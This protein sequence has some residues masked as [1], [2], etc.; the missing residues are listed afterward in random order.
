LARSHRPAGRSYLTP[1]ARLGPSAMGGQGLIA[2]APIPRD[3]LVAIWGNWIMTTAEMWA[4]PAALQ[5]FPVQV[6]YDMFV[7]P[8]SARDVEAVDY[9]NHSCAPNCG[10]RGSVV[11]VARQ[12][13]AAGEELTF[14]YGTT[15]TD[16]W[17]LDCGCG[18]ATCRGRMTG[19]D[20]RDPAFQE[21][22][23]GYLSL[24]IQ[25]LIA[26]ERRGVPPVGLPPDTALAQ[27]PAL[28]RP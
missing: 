27:L 2:V 28:R 22:H 24:Y 10:V 26:Y 6:W 21:R 20:W 5:D 12:A 19:D 23:A 1:K 4:L 13:V 8:K 25:E 14:D 7:G 16:R 9:M 17:S 11:V 3:E 18:A 15:D